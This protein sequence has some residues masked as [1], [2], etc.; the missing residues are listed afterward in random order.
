MSILTV[1]NPRDSALR[2][3]KV[4]NEMSIAEMMRALK[5]TQTAV[6]R[7]L[8]KLARDGLVECTSRPAP[9]GRPLN[10]Y[11]LTEKATTQY[12]PT[13]Y[14][15]LAGQLLDTIFDT[16]GHKGVFDFLV[17]MN[18]KI[19]QEVLPLL[20]DQP[21]EQRVLFLV[22][23]YRSRG[24]MTDFR[25]LPKGRYFLYHRHCAIYNLANKFRQFCFIE[26][27]LIQAVCGTKVTRRQYIF[28]N[29]P[30]CGYLIEA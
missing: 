1:E 26:L 30:L 27:K 4:R 3:L 12:F 16:A 9:K 19:L 14:E 21:L 10:V 23:Y 20:R 7:H 5:L 22:D 24:Y 18:A 25:R 8:E 17:E 15:A 13:G 29:Q 6:R 28:K 2:I 11:R